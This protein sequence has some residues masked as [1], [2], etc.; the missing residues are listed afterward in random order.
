[1]GKVLT[2]IFLLFGELFSLQLVK[3]AQDNGGTQMSSTSFVAR[4]SLGEA[5]VGK[6]SSPTMS[7]ES[8][9]FA[10]PDRDLKIDSQS[11]HHPRQIAIISITP[12][13]FNSS[14]RV[15]F[16]LQ[17][18]GNIEIEILTIDGKTVLHRSENLSSGTHSI[19]WTPA[20]NLP[21]GIYIVRL[22]S[23]GEFVER[24]MLL[25]R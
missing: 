10:N 17:N 2:V 3:Y 7:T 14:C 24:K 18:S 19:K 16:Y 5:L 21:T 12:T 8:G 23:P 22:S 15:E 11:N 4:N 1:M 25:I 20:P 13:P 6:V 9:L